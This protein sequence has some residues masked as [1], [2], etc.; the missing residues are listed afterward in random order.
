VSNRTHC[1]AWS[2]WLSMAAME[3]EKGVRLDTNYY[4]YPNTWIGN[5]PGFMTGSGFPMRMVDASGNMIGVYQANTFMTD[6]SGQSYPA[7][8]D[9]LLDKALGPEGYYGF[10]TTNFHTD[11]ATTAESDATIASARARGVPLISAKQLLDWTEARRAA[12]FAN[13]AWSNGQLTFSIVD[14]GGANGLQ[15]MLPVARTG[16]GRLAALTRGG[17]PV[18]FTTA[19]LKGIEYALFPAVPGAYVATYS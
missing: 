18:A 9:A 13:Q 11:Y 8:T 15:A 3:E 2:D 7:T 14:P 16:A 10:F 12:R 19:T 6:E 17:A 4:H 1:V 5:A